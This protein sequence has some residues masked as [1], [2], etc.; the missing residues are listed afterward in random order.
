MTKVSDLGLPVVG[1]RHGKQP[2]EEIDHFH[3]CPYCGQAVDRRD[4]RQVLWHE[5]PTHKRLKLDS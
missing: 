4:L 1:T 2:A 5:Q 3:T